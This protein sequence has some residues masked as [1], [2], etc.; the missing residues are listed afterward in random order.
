MS[1]VVVFVLLR[2]AFVLL[3][4]RGYNFLGTL[5]VGD[6]DFI[7]GTISTSRGL[8]ML[9]DNKVGTPKVFFVTV[10]FNPNSLDSV[11]FTSH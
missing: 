6:D 1:L 9:T 2:L 7:L 5:L 8:Q 4:V 11:A 10:A 3:L